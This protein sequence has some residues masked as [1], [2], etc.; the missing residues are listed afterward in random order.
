[1]CQPPSQQTE[2]SESNDRLVFDL[3]NRDSLYYGQ[4]QFAARFILQE[5][6]ALR[7]LDHDKIDKTLD[8]RRDF[9]RFT[10]VDITSDK[11]QNCHTV[12]DQLLNLKSPFKSVIAGRS[13][14]YFYTSDLESIKTLSQGPAARIGTISQ[15]NV[16]CAKDTIALRNPKHA[17]RTYFKCHSPT[18]AQMNNLMEFA[19]INSEEL[20]V[21]LGL[22]K[23]FEYAVRHKTHAYRWIMDYH[24]IDHSDMRLVTALALMHPRLIRKTKQI[25]KVNS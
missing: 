19:Q 24:Y 16:V 18:D 23:L 17:F 6:S 3:V 21:S 4:F 8:F 10:Q 7:E 20:K 13:W 5:A 14:I 15:A 25:V 9:T 2:S 1:M 22:Q 11:R 12:C